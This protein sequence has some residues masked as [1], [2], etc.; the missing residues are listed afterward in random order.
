[1]Y[2]SAN[3]TFTA[4]ASIVTLYNTATLLPEEGSSLQAWI[5]SGPKCPYDPVTRT[6]AHVD[7]TFPKRESAHTATLLPD[8]PVLLAGGWICCG[9]SLST[10]AI[11][12]PAHPAPSPFLYSLPGGSQG[13]I[14]YPSL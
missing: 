9:Y 3:G 1:M 14:R 11:Y 6:F 2:D 4:T 10:A 7:G 8:G 13:A 12:H 5:F